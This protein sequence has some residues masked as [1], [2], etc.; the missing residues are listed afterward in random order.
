MFLAALNWKRDFVS[1]LWVKF[2]AF[3]Q[4]PLPV[5]YIVRNVI[6][7]FDRPQ[8]HVYQFFHDDVMLR[9]IYQN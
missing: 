8:L 7:Y 4:M 9:L 5:L 6:A 2:L 3:L 1:F